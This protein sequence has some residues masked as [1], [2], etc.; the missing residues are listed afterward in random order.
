MISLLRKKL[1]LIQL[2][3]PSGKPR[4]VQTTYFRFKGLN[5]PR[6]VTKSMLK[7]A[8]QQF[9]NRCVYCLL[10]KNIEVDHIINHYDGG[11][12]E[13]WNLQTLCENCNTN[14]EDFW[15]FQS[16]ELVHARGETASINGLLMSYVHEKQLYLDHYKNHGILR[17]PLPWWQ[18]NAYGEPI[19]LECF[20]YKGQ[21]SI[22]AQDLFLQDLAL[23]P[24]RYINDW[25][26][27]QI[28]YNPLFKKETYQKK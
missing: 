13:Q 6:R 19:L 23:E 1:N 7:T 24:N 8:R 14:K 2:P 27:K 5:A 15:T 10:S 18:I 28:Q 21:K 12:D 26:E 9:G 22:K 25:M 20:S 4:S 11:P 3:G 17:D 16:K